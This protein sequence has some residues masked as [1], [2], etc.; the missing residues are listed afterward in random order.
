[1][2]TADAHAAPPRHLRF[3]RNL[4]VRAA[5]ADLWRSRPLIAALAE[6]QLRARYKQA[7]FGVAWTLIT[8]LLL[9]IVFTLFFNHVAKIG[10]EGVPYPLFAYLGLIPWT[11]FSVSVSQGS[12]S[13]VLNIALLNKLPCP[14]EVFP[15]SS[16]FVAGVDAAVSLVILVALFVITGTVPQATS[17]WVPLLLI[18][19]FIFTLAVVLITSSVFVYFRDL[20]QIIP[21]LLQ[22]GLLATPV[23]YGIRSIPSDLQGIYSFVNPLGPI[24]D[25]YR[26]VILYGLAPDWSLVAIAAATSIGLLMVGY[27]LFKRLEVGFTDYA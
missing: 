14:R 24:I 5:F 13:L 25:G 3:R 21:I 4:S 23:A 11:F 10:T 9:M 1:L 19:Q 2:P 8:P 7:V 17:V 6:R 16:I 26:R 12:Q 15:I 22:L 18:V 27:L 20:A